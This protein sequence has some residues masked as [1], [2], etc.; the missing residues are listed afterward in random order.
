MKR[1]RSRVLKDRHGRLGYALMGFFVSNK[2]LVVGVIHR[3]EADRNSAMHNNDESCPDPCLY[4]WS[5]S[6]PSSRTLVVDIKF[7][8]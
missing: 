3:H 2:S 1:W 7:L 4:L 8:S 5:Y 6:L